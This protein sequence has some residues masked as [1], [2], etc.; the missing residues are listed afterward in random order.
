MKLW[1]LEMT[2]AYINVCYHAFQLGVSLLGKE[3]K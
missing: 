2:M 3:K 1:M